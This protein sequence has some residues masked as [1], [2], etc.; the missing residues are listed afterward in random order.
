MEWSATGASERSES[1]KRNFLFDSGSDGKPV[2]VD[3]PGSASKTTRTC[4]E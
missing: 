3:R 1:H 2:E 4:R